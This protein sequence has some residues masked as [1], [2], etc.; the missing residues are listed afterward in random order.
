MFRA[1]STLLIDITSMQLF[2]AVKEVSFEDAP[3]LAEKEIELK[4][5]NDGFIQSVAVATKSK[6]LENADVL[7]ELFKGYLNLMNTK[8][9]K[10]LENSKSLRFLVESE[11]LFEEGTMLCGTE[12]ESLYLT[13]KTDDDKV[14]AS[15]RCNETPFDSRNEVIPSN[16][17]TPRDNDE[18]SCLRDKLVSLKNS[19]D[20]EALDFLKRAFEFDVENDSHPTNT[21]K[22]IYKRIQ[23][24]MDQRN[25]VLGKCMCVIRLIYSR[26]QTFF[27]HDYKSATNTDQTL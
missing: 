15:S 9:E 5:V 22:E 13:N 12:D 26:Y 27:C 10:L 6:V 21:R 11:E 24:F 20:G 23:E 25:P 8:G 2:Y 4:D 14:V 19:I 16:E 1:R 18:F 17:E 7:L 3:F